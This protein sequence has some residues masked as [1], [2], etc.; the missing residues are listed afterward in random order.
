MDMDFGYVQNGSGVDTGSANSDGDNGQVTN[1][2]TTND[3]SLNN[4]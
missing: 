4:L 3:E 2:N 1:L